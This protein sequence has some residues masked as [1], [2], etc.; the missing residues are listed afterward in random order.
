MEE[1]KAKREEAE[2]ALEALQKAL[3]DALAARKV[4]FASTDASS[5]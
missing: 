1:S 5:S 4:S 2:R 3:K